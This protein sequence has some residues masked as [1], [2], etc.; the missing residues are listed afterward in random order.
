MVSHKNYNLNADEGFVIFWTSK[1][2]TCFMDIFTLKIRSQSIAYLL[3]KSEHIHWILDIE[4]EIH[5][6]WVIWASNLQN[7]RTS[8]CFKVGQSMQGAW[9]SSGQ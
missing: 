5:S 1:L 8:L 4:D 3:N 2:I 6:I 7:A 9:A